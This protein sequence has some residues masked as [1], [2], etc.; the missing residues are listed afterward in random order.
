MKVIKKSEFLNRLAQ[1]QKNPSFL[2]L[3]TTFMLTS[4]YKKIIEPI[5]PLLEKNDVDSFH[6]IFTCFC[7]AE[8]FFQVHPSTCYRHYRTQTHLFKHSFAF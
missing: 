4:C 1:K 8:R 7:S 2:T 3:F 6:L 5:R